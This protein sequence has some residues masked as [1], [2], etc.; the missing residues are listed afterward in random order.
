MINFSNRFYDKN[1]YKNNFNSSYHSAKETIPIILRLLNPKSIVDMGC[2]QGTWISVFKEEGINKIK[3]VD[4]QQ[5]KLVIDNKDFLRHD[6]RKP[7]KLKNKFDLAISLE[8]AEHIE[9][10]YSDIFIENLTNASDVV[11]FSAAIPN[12]EGINHINEQWHLFWIKLF[13]KR[14]YIAIDLI[15]PYILLNN[16]ISYDYRQNMILFVKKETLEKNPMKYI[17]FFDKSKQYMSRK[18]YAK[19]LSKPF[20]LAYRINKQ[21]FK[22]IFDNILDKILFKKFFGDICSIKIKEKYY[23]GERK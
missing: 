23:M 12:Q 11:L 8:V 15:R 18:S 1:F 19:Q 5:S 6:L 17:P 22:N 4:F 7:L 14:N 13:E 10:K 16:K 3:G 9:N 2:G 20:R 21:F